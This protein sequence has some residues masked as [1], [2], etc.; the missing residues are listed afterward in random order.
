MKFQ[1][2]VINGIL[3]VKYGVNIACQPPPPPPSKNPGHASVRG[4]KG[5]RLN[6]SKAL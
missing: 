1:N 6:K 5:V 4:A 2:K 3:W